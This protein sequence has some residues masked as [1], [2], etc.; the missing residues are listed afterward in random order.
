MTLHS[1][2]R[3]A[4][5]AS[6]L[7]DSGR[8]TG[9][10]WNAALFRAVDLLSTLPVDRTDRRSLEVEV[11]NAAFLRDLGSVRQRKVSVRQALLAAAGKPTF[12][13]QVGVALAH[14]NVGYAASGMLSVLGVNPERCVWPNPTW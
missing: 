12:D 3:Y 4:W 14:A 5:V 1:S 7:G 10:R 11:L 8:I 13:G 6:K 9:E 2:E